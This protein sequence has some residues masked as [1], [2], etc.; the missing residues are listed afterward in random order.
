[1]SLKAKRN[2]F[3]SPED[4]AVSVDPE[5]LQELMAEGYTPAEAMQIAA[6][7]MDGARDEDGD[8][9][10]LHTACHIENPEGYKRKNR[11]WRGGP[12]GGW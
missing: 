3:P 6:A 4:I 2:F 1:M 7:T 11:K 9:W 12:E 5:F 10:S 8:V